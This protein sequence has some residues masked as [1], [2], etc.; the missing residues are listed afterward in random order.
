MTRALL[1]CI[2]LLL[3]GAHYTGNM[4]SLIDFFDIGVEPRHILYVAALPVTC[5]TAFMLLRD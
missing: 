2:A 4:K 5:I 3:V 1:V